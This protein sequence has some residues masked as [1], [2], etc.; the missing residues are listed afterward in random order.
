MGTFMPVASRAR[1]KRFTIDSRS[2]GDDPSGTRSLSWKFTPYAP[3]PASS[4]TASTGSRTGRTSWP[5]GSR[6][7][8][9][10]VHR[11]NVNR[12][13]GRGSYASFILAT[14][15]FG[16]SGHASR[17]LLQWQPAGGH[18]VLDRSAHRLDDPHA[19]VTLVVALD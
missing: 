18:A 5:K 10:T 4:C 9:P 17:R 19:R 1:R 6:P 13:S 12:C 7:R 3:M 2:L 16:S 8:L 14:V 15:A 11:P